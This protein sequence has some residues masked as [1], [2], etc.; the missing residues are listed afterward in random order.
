MTV[1]DESDTT[2]VNSYIPFGLNST[3]AIINNNG[4]SYPVYEPTIQGKTRILNSK[5]VSLKPSIEG[6]EALKDVPSGVCDTIDLAN[7]LLSLNTFY[8]VLDGSLTYTNNGAVG[9]LIEYII[10]SFPSTISIPSGQVSLDVRCFNLPVKNS[11]TE[12]CIFM[13]AG[14]LRIRLLNTIN[15]TSYFTQN[16]TEVIYPVATP[17]K[18]QLTPKEIGAYAE[19]KK[20]IS[21]PFVEDKVTIDETG[22]ATWIDASDDLVLVGSENWRT[23]ASTDTHIGFQ[24]REPS[25]GIVLGR[26]K[27]GVRCAGL[28]E[29]TRNQILNEAMTIMKEGIC[30][31]GG[32]SSIIV[33]L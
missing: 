17:T 7:S 16:P 24:Y 6:L 19:Y 26:D 22:S 27:L 11:T 4:Q 5:L 33:C 29:Y 8:V 25:L 20:V 1:I 12:S 23:W 28:N 30:S 2:K 31:D 10:N 9:N 13:S 15:P 3:Q 32:E 21:L 14:R 18:I